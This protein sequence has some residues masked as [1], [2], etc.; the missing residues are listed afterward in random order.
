MLILW[1]LQGE[2]YKF[3]QADAEKYKQ[4]IYFPR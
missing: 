4:I 3:S 1:T 2:G